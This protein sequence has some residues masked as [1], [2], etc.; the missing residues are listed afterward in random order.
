MEYEL[1]ESS[2]G[3]RAARVKLSPTH[4]SVL[5]RVSFEAEE[6]NDIEQQRMGWQ[7]TLESF[8]RHVAQATT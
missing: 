1:I 8:A 3:E 4:N 2:F 6:E 5:V 7:S